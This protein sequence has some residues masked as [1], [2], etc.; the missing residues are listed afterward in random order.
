MVYQLL[1]QA[2]ALNSEVLLQPFLRTPISPDWNRWHCTEAFD[3]FFLCILSSLSVNI[4]TIL[5]FLQCSLRY[6]WF[7]NVCS[8]VSC[9]CS[10][11]TI[12]KDAMSGNI[13]FS[14]IFFSFFPSFSL[15]LSLFLRPRPPPGTCLFIE[16]CLTIYLRGSGMK[17]QTFSGSPFAWQKNPLPLSPVETKKESITVLHLGMTNGNVKYTDTLKSLR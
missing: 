7:K 5:S 11:E 17:K 6:E 16:I 10:N 15:S 2:T 1:L 12:I 8:C 9:V 4:Q 3:S 14:T 13:W